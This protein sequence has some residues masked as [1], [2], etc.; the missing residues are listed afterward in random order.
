MLYC[1]YRKKG[2]REE[3]PLYSKWDVES[4]GETIKQQLPPP[5]ED[6]AAV[7]EEKP[8]QQVQ[9]QVVTSC[10]DE[11]NHKWSEEDY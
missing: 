10:T 9:L 1:K 4:N 3:P 8:K 11:I 5:L 7:V 6:F 2:I